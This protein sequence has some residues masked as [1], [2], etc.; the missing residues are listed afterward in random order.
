M[1]KKIYTIEVQVA[2]LLRSGKK[3][4]PQMAKQLGTSEN[5]INVGIHHIRK[6][7]LMPDEEI[8]RTGKNGNS[9]YELVT[10]SSLQTDKIKRLKTNFTNMRR[11]IREVIKLSLISRAT[12]NPQDITALNNMIINLMTNMSRE[13]SQMT[14]L[15]IPVANI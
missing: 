8:L 11:M 12:T 6:N 5:M 2:T 14:M 7:V 15:Q 9:F 10:N 4:V 1:A 3:S 13:V